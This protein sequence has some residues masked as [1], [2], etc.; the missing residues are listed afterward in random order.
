MSQKIKILRILN[1]FNLGGPIYNASYLSKYLEDDFET[2]L[3]GGQKLEEEES[4]LFIPESLGVQTHIIP[5]MTRSVGILSDLKAYRHISNIIESFKPDI[6]HTHAS[7]AGALGRIAASRAGVKHIV[8]TFHGH[9]FEHYF[10]SLKTSLVKSTERYLAKKSQAIIAISETQ[11]IDLVERF[12][13]AE[14]EKVHVINLGFDLERF[15]ENNEE[16]R[17]LFRQKYVLKEDDIAIGI[18]G[19]LV[20]IKN[21]DLF[22]QA[23]AELKKEHSHVRA[24]IMGDGNLK[25]SL[26][27]KAH[28]LGLT[29]ES[30]NADVVFTSW[31]KQVDQVLPGLDIVALTSF[32]EGT[33]VSLIEAQ[34]AKKPVISSDVGGVKDVIGKDCGLLYA[35]NDLTA[36]K[37]CMEQLISNSKLRDEMGQKGYEWAFSKFTAQRLANDIKKLYIELLNQ[38]G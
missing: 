25:M 31:I 13:I 36:L 19:R 8:H 38:E 7:K 32:N 1:R 22:I 2:M 9:V 4:A 28:K 14:S 18:I 15:H 6:V 27:E 16:K 24:F 35:S 17:K 5:E 20:P 21:H 23:I 11:K 10:G 30:E 33:P 26:K 3:I 37:N 29:T 34:A 12:K